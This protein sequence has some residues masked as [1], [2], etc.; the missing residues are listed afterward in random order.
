MHSDDALRQLSR[1]GANYQI[2]IIADTVKA[3]GVIFGR[4]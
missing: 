4:I 1:L 3:L 2:G